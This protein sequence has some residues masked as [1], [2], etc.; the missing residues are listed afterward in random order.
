MNLLSTV[1]VALLPLAALAAEPPMTPE[2]ASQ[3]RDAAAKVQAGDYVA[4]SELLNALAAQYPRVP[5]IFTTRCSLQLGLRRGATAEADCAYALALRPNLPSAVYGLAIAEDS[6]GKTELAIGHYRQYASLEDP[7]AIY[8][9]QAL[10]RANQLS[11]KAAPGAG[12]APAPVAAA[13][14]PTGPVG[15][16]LIY[17]NH[18]LGADRWGVGGV[19]QIS[20][21]LDGRPAGDIEHDQ[22]VELQASP[23][24][25]VLE[26]RFTLIS[27]FGGPQ[28]LTVPV[29]IAPNGQ[30]WLNFDTV[31]GAIQL[32]PVAPD[33]GRREIAEDCKKAW[34]R[35]L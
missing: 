2:A 9:A 20:L 34:T 11:A 7:Q 33:K 10:A 25:H 30:T 29:N 3:Y 35:R 17:R 12:P 16:L 26:A 31:G 22:Y 23:G 27:M 14:V 21:L 5:E 28:V 6:L 18:H 19:G 13:P 24:S 4:A 8:K 32:V 1:L 15:T